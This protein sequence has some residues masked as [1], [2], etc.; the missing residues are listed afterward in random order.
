MKCAFEKHMHLWKE[1]WRGEAEYAAAIYA[2]TREDPDVS[3][4]FLEADGFFQFFV[5][6]LTYSTCA[7]EQLQIANLHWQMCARECQFY[8]RTVSWY[9]QI[10]SW[11]G[12]PQRISKSASQI[13]G[14][15]CCFLQV[16]G[17]AAHCC[18]N[19]WQEMHISIPGSKL[20][21]RNGV[22]KIAN[23]CFQGLPFERRAFFSRFFF[24]FFNFSVYFFIF[25]TNKV[26][27]NFGSQMGSPPPRRPPPL[28]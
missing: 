18:L 17:Y 12:R 10:Y 4:E 22:W 7:G 21:V 3:R 13:W 27:K 28:H 24:R 9:P 20:F 26:P 1:Q 15:D 14:P 16:C 25:Q 6:S 11:G 19:F 23:S 8:K 2:Y 5:S